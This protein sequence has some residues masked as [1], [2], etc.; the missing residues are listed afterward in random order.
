MIV[1]TNSVSPRAI[2]RGAPQLAA[3]P[4]WLAMTAGIESPGENNLAVMSGEEP[5]TRAAAIVS[6][7][8]RPRPSMT[9]PTMPPAVG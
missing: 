7:I 3:S 5:I 6:P 2:E 8:A 9:A 4:H 1:R